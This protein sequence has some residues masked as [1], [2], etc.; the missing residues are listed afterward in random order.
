MWQDSNEL[1]DY[2]LRELE[3]AINNQKYQL[4]IILN[5]NFPNDTN[6]MQRYCNNLRIKKN[7]ELLRKKYKNYD[8]KSTVS[9]KSS[10]AK[11]NLSKTFSP[12][13]WKLTLQRR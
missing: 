4:E 12:L 8:I 3:V 9:L 1:L 10:F 5:S 6:L 7:T 13:V 11:A 2:A